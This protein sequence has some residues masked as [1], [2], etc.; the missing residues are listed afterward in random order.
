MNDNSRFSLG[1]RRWPPSAAPI[2]QTGDPANGTVQAGIIPGENDIC[3]A[4]V[5][6]DR[7]GNSTIIE[8]YPTL[9]EAEAAALAFARQKNRLFAPSTI[10]TGDAS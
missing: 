9:G 2:I 4:V 5:F 7:F 1:R 3:Y 6:R 8:C 10:M